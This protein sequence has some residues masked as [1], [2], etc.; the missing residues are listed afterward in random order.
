MAVCKPVQNDAG[1]ELQVVG[2]RAAP[3][4]VPRPV[5]VS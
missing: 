3:R 1:V 2:D 4:E 5:P